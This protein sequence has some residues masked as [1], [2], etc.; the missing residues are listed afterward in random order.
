MRI[1]ILHASAGSGH[2]R[3][4]EAL[5]SALALRA[6]GH[7]VIVRDILD[8][9]PLAFKETYARGYLRIVRK[10]PEL[11]GYM[12]TQA[13]RKSQVPW[14]K[15]S[16]M[17]FNAINAH[18]FFD[19]CRE[20]APDCIACTHFMPLE[21]ISSKSRRRKMDVPFFA[22]VTDFAVH[23]L[24]IVEDVDCYYVATQEARRHLVRRGQPEDRVLVSGIPIDP[25]FASTEPKEVARQR[26][27]SQPG[28]PVILSL[29][30]GVGVGPTVALVRSFGASEKE[31]HLLVVAGANED[32]R[33]EAEAAAQGVHVPVTVVGFVNNIHELMD[34]ADIVVSK[35][36]GL[37][38]SE[39]LAKG[40]PML[41]VDPI[42][43]QEQRNCE[44]LLE[45]GAAAR[46]FE[47][48][49]APFKIDV[50][51]SDQDRVRRME[52]AAQTLGKPNAA[53][54]IAA[55]IVERCT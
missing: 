13:D 4:A 26:L 45:A 55:D 12:Y 40:T 29:A 54:D 43:G 18:S 5:A 52:A 47:I 31:Y 46:L 42:P 1:L 24:W 3:A 11:W 33:R 19:F 35:P 2:R 38:S 15:W 14:R 28:L 48:E 50:I 10:A 7:E 41:I 36:G 6:E 16:R 8:F 21:L 51:C 44:F 49:D 39:A 37:T 30:G 27:G 34:A 22:C 32:L 25:V 53:A 17:V 9:T 20:F 23:S